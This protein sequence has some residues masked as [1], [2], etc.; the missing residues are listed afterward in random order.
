MRESEAETRSK[1]VGSKQETKRLDRT[2]NQSAPPPIN[3]S[4]P[5]SKTNSAPR[6]PASITIGERHGAMATI[7]GRWTRT[8]WDE[9]GGRQIRPDGER[10]DRRGYGRGYY[11]EDRPRRRV[12]VCVEYEDGDEYCHYP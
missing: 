1:S 5:E 6:I 2:C 9:C 11:D 10:A 3:Q 4:N 12:K 8:T 7:G